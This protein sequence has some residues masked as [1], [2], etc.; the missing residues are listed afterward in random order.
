MDEAVD[1]PHEGAMPTW[2]VLGGTPGYQHHATVVV[3][4]QE[5]YLSVVLPQDEEHR[6]Q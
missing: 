3:D 5:G 4:V 6:V 2:Y 1:Q